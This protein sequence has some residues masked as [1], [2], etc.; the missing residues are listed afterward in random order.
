MPSGIYERTEYHKKIIRDSHKNQI[1]WN[2]GIKQPELGLKRLGKN[3]PNWKGNNVKIGRIHRRIELKYGKPRYC[4]H[5]KR[6][7]KKLY[8]WSNKDHKYSEN[9]KDWQRLCR[10]CHTKFDRLSKQHPNKGKPLSKKHKENVSKALLNYYK[11]HKY[12]F[13]K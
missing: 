13:K 1:P 5:C 4:E 11:Y 6:T 10:G 3:N 2:K 7:D 12:K 8:E 9:I